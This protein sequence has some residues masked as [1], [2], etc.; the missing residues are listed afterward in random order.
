MHGNPFHLITTCTATGQ[1]KHACSQLKAASV[2]QALNIIGE[3]AWSQEA[4]FMTQATVPSP[5][6]SLTCTAS[7]PDTVLVAWQ[8]PADGG[9]PVHAYQVHRGD[10]VDGDFQP[11]YSGSECQYRASGLR[12]GVQYRFRVLA[13]NEVGPLAITHVA[14]CLGSVILVTSVNLNIK[15][16]R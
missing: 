15:R 10:G 2:Q 8:A 3:S 1:P 13:E 6:D 5:P 14:M 16:H 7:G 11:M 9:A 4:S 12:S